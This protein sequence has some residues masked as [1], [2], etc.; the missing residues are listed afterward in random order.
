[1]FE[2]PQDGGD[3]RVGPDPGHPH[4]LPRSGSSDPHCE[5]KVH[6]EVVAWYRDTVPRW[7]GTHR[8]G[9]SSLEWQPPLPSQQDCH[10]VE[11]PEPFLG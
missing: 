8:I 10:S 6:S 3:S 2:V 11:E 4:P 7:E 9:G 1:M 5:V